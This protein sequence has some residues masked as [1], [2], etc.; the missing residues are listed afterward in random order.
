MTAPAGPYA[1]GTYSIAVMPLQTMYFRFRWVGDAT[2][3][4][5]NSNVVPVQV[6][7]SLGV[8]SCPSSVK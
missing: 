5:S 7:P 1:T 6:K 3:A 8:P 4:P 2:Y